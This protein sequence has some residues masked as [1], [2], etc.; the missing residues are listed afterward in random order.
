MTVSG[1][2]AS[3]AATTTAGVRTRAGGWFIAGFALAQMGAFVSFIPLLA[4]LVPLKAQ[5]IDPAA[6]AAMMAHVSMWGAVMAGAANLAAGLISDRTLSRFGR[7][8]PW[9]AIGLLGTLGSYALIA[10][11]HGY[12]PLL[13]GL[14]AFQFCFN[15]LYGPLSAMLADHVPDWQKGRVSGFASVAQPLGSLCGIALTGLMIGRPEFRYLAIGAILLVTVGPFVALAPDPPNHTQAWLAFARRPRRAS[16]V[17]L[18]ANPDLAIA[19]F[20]RLFMQIAIS[21]VSIFALY[22]LQDRVR[23]GP[24]TT[25]EAQ[26]AVLTLVSTVLHVAASLAGGFL[27]DRL[28][29]RKPFM[30][31]SSLALAAAMLVMALAPNWRAVIAAYALLGVGAGLY[32]MASAALVAQIL[33]SLGDAAGDLGVFNLAV[34][35]PQVMSPL[36]GLMLLG[37]GQNYFALFA[38]TA[39]LALA[40]GTF[41]SLIRK[42]K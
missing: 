17:N 42:V 27:S 32:A 35:A 12:W 16:I 29:R 11:A 14:L 5:E 26:L 30:V 18:G 33:P 37:A 31:A 38:V 34:T 13:G 39:V 21:V 19:W 24:S 7:R 41:A 40:G 9:M 8:R 22:Y 15:F 36:L 20:S 6:K 25:A 2:Q 10:S 1:T 23:G 4:I 28:G 3:Q